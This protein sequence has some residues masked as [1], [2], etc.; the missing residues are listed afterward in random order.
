MEISINNKIHLYFHCSLYLKE[1]PNGQPPREF[2][3]LEVGWTEIGLQV[4]C[5]RHE[6]NVISIDFEGQQHPATS[7]AN[8]QRG[9]NHRGED[10]PNGD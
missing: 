9:G 3:E 7:Q 6:M 1:L 5:K 4:W 8:R 10:V 2:A